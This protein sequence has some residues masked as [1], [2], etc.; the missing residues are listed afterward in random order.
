MTNEYAHINNLL[1]SENKN[2]INSNK[3]FN[4]KISFNNINYQTI[5]NEQEIVHQRTKSNYIQ[6]NIKKNININNPIY[7]KV[8][9]TEI[10]N[11]YIKPAIRIK[12][13]NKLYI[14]KPIFNDGNNNAYGNKTSI[15]NN[16]GLNCKKLSS[17]NTNYINNINITNN[18]KNNANM[19]KDLKNNNIIQNK[20]IKN[21]N[22]NKYILE[23]IKK[24][25][26]QH[27]NSITS[28]INPTQ[29]LNI[30]D[31][32]IS[33]NKKKLSK[34]NLN[35]TKGLKEK[36]VLQIAF[37][38][39]VNGNTSSRNYNQ[40]NILEPS[41]TANSNYSTYRINNNRQMKKKNQNNN[42]KRNYNLNIN[43]NNEININENN[44]INNSTYM[45][46][47]HRINSK[48]MGKGGNMLR[49]YLG[50]VGLR[51]KEKNKCI[52]NLKQKKYNVDGAMN[53]NRNNNLTKNNDNLIFN[54][55]SK[56]SKKIKT[57]NYTNKNINNWLNSIN[58]NFINTLILNNNSVDNKINSNNSNNINK[59]NNNIIKSYHTKSVTNL[60]D[61]M[62]HNKKLISLYKN[63]SKSK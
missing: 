22:F 32:I 23:V 20:N 27:Y 61:L 21:T 47:S 17:N 28:Q 43:I 12:K 6:N 39:F 59:N 48:N 40:A 60:S 10:N 51:Q 54:A 31:N 35:N 36:D 15:I 29:N 56:K 16:N 4:N 55:N 26:H 8:L 3:I 52:V 42:N 9:N 57:R 46:H 19:N 63:V 37:S 38:L 11:A 7:T 13:N 62:F 53:S 44:T 2:N 18:I 25:K 41:N 33:K 24:T 1:F 45:N 30:K 5:S 34:I 49:G 50:D 14:N 58:N